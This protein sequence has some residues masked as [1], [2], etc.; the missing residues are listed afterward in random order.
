MVTGGRVR[1]GCIQ[2]FWN[3]LRDSI[4]KGRYCVSQLS[5]GQKLGPIDVDFYPVWHLREQTRD[6]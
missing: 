3:L 4:Q 5:S 6:Y 2:P 1:W